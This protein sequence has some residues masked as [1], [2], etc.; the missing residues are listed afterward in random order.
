MD[1]ACIFSNTNAMAAYSNAFPSLQLFSDG[2]PFGSPTMTHDE[3][4]LFAAATAAKIF[5]SFALPTGH[6]S[7]EQLP[8]QLPSTS[9]M[10][11]QMKNIGD[12][13]VSKTENKN[14]ERKDR[15][16]EC[17]IDLRIDTKKRQEA[18]TSNEQIR[19]LLL[20]TTSREPMVKSTLTKF[21]TL[22]IEAVGEGKRYDD[23]EVIED[24]EEDGNT[25]EDDQDEDEDRSNDSK[26]LSVA[27]SNG[28]GGRGAMTCYSID[29]I[30]AKHIS[31]KQQTV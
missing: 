30:M 31:Q 3:Q 28:A 13:V 29:S 27:C 10:R 26:G 23:G 6:E 17:S 7:F 16:D 2:F 11:A 9:L 8:Q 24:I 21:E 22:P 1:P 4:R 20:R 18:N 14:E 25:I 5:A 15:E 19:S 12:T